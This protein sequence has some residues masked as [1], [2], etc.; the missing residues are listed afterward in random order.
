MFSIPTDSMESQ[1]AVNIELQNL[2]AQRTSKLQE[3]LEIERQINKVAVRIQT[4]A[5]SSS[6]AQLVSNISDTSSEN[7]SDLDEAELS[8]PSVTEEIF[9]ADKSL[10]VGRERSLPSLIARFLK[11]KKDGET[12]SSIVKYCLSV[13]YK[14]ESMD[15]TRSVTQALYNLKVKKVIHKDKITRK[16]IFG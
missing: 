3:L 16:F 10:F 4:V 8:T 11:G 12:L 5:H 15:F 14:S 9:D 1:I 6:S 13:G 7:V 2:F